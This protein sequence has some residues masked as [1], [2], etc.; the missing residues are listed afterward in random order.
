MKRTLRRL[1]GIRELVEDLARLEMEGRRA[2]MRA[3]EEAAERQ[4][5]MRRSMQAG[6]IEDLTAGTEAGREAWLLKSFD[7]EIALRKRA[8]LELLAEQA[9][10]PLER[11]REELM[12][13]RLERRQVEILHAAEM[14]EEEKSRIRDD[15]N[16]TDDWFQG[17][18]SSSH[19]TRR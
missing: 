9:R 11:S 19:R 6:A 7:S 18:P 10:P 15:Q 3:L 2:E 4:L 12:A 16:R 1:L 14:Q 13:K 17:R 8:R 5:Q